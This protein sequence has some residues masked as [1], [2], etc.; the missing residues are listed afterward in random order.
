ML[1][2]PVELVYKSLTSIVTTYMPAPENVQEKCSCC[3]R[4]AKE[5]GYQ[6]YRLKNCYQQPVTHC[7]QCQS[8]FVSAPEI[9]GI[10][11]PARPTTSQKFGMWVGVGALIN[12][13]ELSAILLAPPGVVNKLPAAFLD[14]VQVVTATTGQQINYLFEADLQYPLIY[15]QDFGRKT[16]ELIRSLRV[17]N[18]SEALYACCDTLMTRTNEAIFRINLHQ[19]KML[20]EQMKNTENSQSNVFIRTTELLAYG[21][22]SPAKASEAFI[23]NNVTHLVRLLPADPHQRL[24]LMRLLK[25]VL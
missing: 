3:E 13:H 24:L 9:L 12:V 23:K 16:Y 20:Y 15:I 5:F 25:K 18:S 10:E 14:K 8:F 4:P 17:S 19:A 22:M 1:S 6:G 2:C 7:P 21:R 11:N